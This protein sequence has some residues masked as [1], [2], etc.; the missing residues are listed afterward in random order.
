[1]WPRSPPHDLAPARGPSDAPKSGGRHT[2][3]VTQLGV[4]PTVVGHSGRLSMLTSRDRSLSNLTV[5]NPVM[6]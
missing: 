1:M 4:A 3:D 5:A 2:A 6:S